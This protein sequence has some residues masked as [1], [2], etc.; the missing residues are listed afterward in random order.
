MLVMLIIGVLAAMSAPAFR[1]TMAM[2][3]LRSGANSV[4]ALARQARSLASAHALRYR[5]NFDPDQNTFW[6]TGELDPLSAYGEFDELENTW[7][8]HFALPRRVSFKRIVRIEDGE[9]VDSSSEEAYVTFNPDGTADEAKIELG[10]GDGD[11]VLVRVSPLTG[12]VA[13]DASEE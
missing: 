7:G 4:I 13:V 12:R 10:N 1:G 6:I 11:T 3:A 8:R 2:A 9:E 5:L